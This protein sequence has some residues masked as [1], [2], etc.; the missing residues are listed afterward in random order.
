MRKSSFQ[1]LEL[2]SNNLLSEVSKN[3]KLLLH[4]CCGP[5]SLEPVRV[6]RERGVEPTIFFSNSNIAPKAEYDER[7]SAIKKWAK[8]NDV[9]F[10]EDTYDNAEWIDVV[11]SCKG[12]KPERCRECYKMRLNHACEFAKNNGYDSV[13]TTLTISPYQHIDTIEEE[14][15]NACKTCGVK[16]A[17]EDYS[18]H[19]RKAQNRAKEEGVYKQKYC[20]CLLSKKEAEDEIKEM[21]KRK[22]KAQE[23]REIELDKKRKSNKEYADKQA[24]KKMLLKQFKE[25]TKC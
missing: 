23:I 18:P 21:Q 22:A 1:I 5:C 25:N 7:L 6:L 20:G 10:I 13:G 16:S 11:K 4:A 17:F 2:Q 19:Y 15:N 9:E 3:N 12:A 8:Q 14:L 24:R